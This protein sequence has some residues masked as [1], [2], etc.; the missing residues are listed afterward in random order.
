M[1]TTF[2]NCHGIIKRETTRADLKK[3]IDKVLSY[4]EE[5]IR[6]NIE[7]KDLAVWFQICLVK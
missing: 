3:K 4:I 2:Q 5:N 1:K 7:I 6:K